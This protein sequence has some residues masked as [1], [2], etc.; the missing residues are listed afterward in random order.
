MANPS[1]L[2]NTTYVDAKGNNARFSFYVNADTAARAFGFGPNAFLPLVDVLTNAAR[3]GTSGGFG[4]LHLP[5]VYGTQ[6]T[7]GS[8]EDKANFTLVDQAGLIHHYQIPAPKSA[9]FLADQETVNIAQT[10]VAAFIAYILSVGPNGEFI[11]TKGGEAFGSV[12]GGIRIRRK[13]HRR[14]NIFTKNPTETGPAE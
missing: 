8:I 7:F 13:I 12:V 9:I 3:N 6:A 11:S 5:G 2:Y 10:D 4:E 1:T 14:I